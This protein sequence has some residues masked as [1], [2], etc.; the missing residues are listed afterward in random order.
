MKFTGK[1]INRRVWALEKDR[2]RKSGVLGILKLTEKNAILC[3]I[4]LLA[5]VMMISDAVRRKLF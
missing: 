5:E 2:L 4:E 1:N 3:I